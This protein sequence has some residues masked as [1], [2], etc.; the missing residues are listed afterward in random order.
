LIQQTR[1]A[2]SRGFLRHVA[3]GALAL[4]AT[5]CLSTSGGTYRQAELTGTRFKVSWVTPLN[6]EF[7]TREQFQRVLSSPKETLKVYCA[8][9]R[10]RRDWS[11]PVRAIV[12]RPPAGIPIDEASAIKG[13][14]YQAFKAVLGPGI[15]L[16]EPAP[17]L[18]GPVTAQV[19]D[20]V[21]LPAPDRAAAEKSF[22]ETRLSPS[23][24]TLLLAFQGESGL[25]LGAIDSPHYNIERGGSEV[26]DKWRL[27]AAP[28]PASRSDGLMGVIWPARRFKSSTG[29]F[30]WP[31]HPAAV[32][33][34][35]LLPMQFTMLIP[36]AVQ[37]RYFGA[38]V[39]GS[40]FFL[41]DDGT[42]DLS[43]AV[44]DRQKI[45]NAYFSKA[46]VVDEAQTQD[47]DVVQFNLRFDMSLFCAYARPVDDLLTK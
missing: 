33:E 18:T 44:K 28:I 22:R 10:P 6:D 27:K 24:T 2:A 15:F 30:I 34:A 1:I 21:A 13:R 14:V 41:R 12:P 38:A 37:A 31:V 20:V 17:A 47:P 4:L 40:P 8:S 19:S 11:L 32:L 36:P 3:P 25:L 16:D 5:S 39:P 29:D 23:V 46:I 9:G 35:A 45:W 26:E 7:K 42:F 43:Q